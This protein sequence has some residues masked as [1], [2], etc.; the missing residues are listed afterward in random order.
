[1]IKRCAP[2]IGVVA[3][4][5]DGYEPLAA[6]YPCEA[7]SKM[8]THLSRGEFSLQALVGALVRSRRM[9]VER[10]KSTDRWQLANWNSPHDLSVTP[11]G[12]GH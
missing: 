3:R 1:M 4:T 9:H 11:V 10:L 5:Q 8:E 12:I 6:I 2:G 7:L